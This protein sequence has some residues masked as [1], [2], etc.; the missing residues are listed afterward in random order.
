MTLLQVIDTARALVNEPLSAGRTFPD[1]T[2]SFWTDSILIDYFNVI[3]QDVSLEVMQSF[4]DYFLTQTTLNISANVTE[5]TLPTDFVKIRRVEDI[6]GSINPVEI[7]PVTLNDKAAGNRIFTEVSGI[8][9][10]GGYYIKGDTIVFTQTP[11]TTEDSSIRV[12]YVKSLADISAGSSI[13]EIP[14]EHHRVLVWGMVKYMLFQ[15]QSDTTKADEEYQRLLIKLRMQ[16]ENRQI[17]RP[18]RVKISQD[19]SLDL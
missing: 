16:A 3:Q 12:Y 9:V 4:E 19:R 1:N 17:Q 11:A 8:F 2:S 5:Y 10:G 18:R 15:Q 14:T 7:R 13:S 6:R